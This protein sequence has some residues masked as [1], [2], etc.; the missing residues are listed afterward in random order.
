MEPVP[1][2]IHLLGPFEVRVRGAAV[3][4]GR[5]R[6]VQRLLALL[7]LRQGREVSRSWLAG[8]FWPESSPEQAFLNLRR[9]LMDLRQALGPEAERL[10]SPSRDSLLLDLTGAAV[11]LL[12]FDAA[13]AVG[14]EGSLQ[15]AVLLYRGP[16]LEG[17]SE[18]WIF[19]EREARREACLQALERL[20]DLALARGEAAAALGHLRRAEALDPLRDSV[21][22]RRMQA[23]AA[24]G[25]LPT[26]LLSF[27]DYR[28]RLHQEMN[29]EPDPETTRLFQEL[30]AGR[31]PRRGDGATGTAS[32]RGG[33]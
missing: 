21:Q 23:L 16:L 29:L 10:R 22:Q 28:L 20:A 2:S 26:A 1:F 27:R 4:S 11:D 18:E 3:R 30:Q 9:N 12:R 33:A 13:V 25:E 32:L 6:S 17:C 19:G 31:R 24:S 8:T 7:V 14:D 15:E 5:T